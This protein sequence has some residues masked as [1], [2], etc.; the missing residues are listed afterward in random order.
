MKRFHIHVAVADLAANI[1]FYSRLFGRAPAKEK[2]D[3]AK[4]MLDDPRI[5]FA[6]SSRGHANGIN[7]LG[8]QAETIEELEELKALA[9]QASA[10][11]TLVQSEAACCHAMSKKHWTTD[12]QGIAWEHFL[13]M[14]DIEVYGE[15]TAVPRGACCLPQS[16]KQE[17]AVC[18]S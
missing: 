2:P 11:T 6:I 18:C 3:Y 9:D 5:N 13:T 4:W 12:P 10:S 17:P 14:S 1:A 7:H 8:M 15:D 16:E